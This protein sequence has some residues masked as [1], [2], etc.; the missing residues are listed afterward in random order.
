[1]IAENEENGKVR[2]GRRAKA[3]PTGQRSVGMSGERDDGY[4]A[5]SSLKILQGI[6]ERRRPR[7]Q[8]TEKRRMHK[9][10]SMPACNFR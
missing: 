5:R 1:M 7:D 4:G 8:P 6:D 3:S 10:A 2:E 9:R